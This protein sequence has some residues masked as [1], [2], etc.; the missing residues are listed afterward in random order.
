[1]NDDLTLNQCAT[2]R[3]ELRSN[4]ERSLS[5]NEELTKVYSPYEAFKFNEPGINVA[6][7]YPLTQDSVWVESDY[8]LSKGLDEV[9][10][11]AVRE[12]IKEKTD[13][14]TRPGILK[15]KLKYR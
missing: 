4:L 10:K 15:Y 12:A 3:A 11:K 7:A 8:T 2:I 1:M 5:N 14:I 13:V 9:I 6:E